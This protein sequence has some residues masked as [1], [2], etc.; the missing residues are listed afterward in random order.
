MGLQETQGV[1]PIVII[2]IWLILGWLAFAACRSLHRR[3]VTLRWWLCLGMTAA[4]GIGLGVYFGF[5]FE[6]QP[7]PR[8]KLFSLPIPAAALVLETHGDGTE[9]WTDFVTPVPELVASANVLF[10]AF[11]SLYPVWLGNT[12]WRLFRH[13]VTASESPTLSPPRGRGG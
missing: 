3:R 2:G 5:F 10:F 13:R 12:C 11:V 1:G 7:F 8:M 4:I 6:Y 9:G